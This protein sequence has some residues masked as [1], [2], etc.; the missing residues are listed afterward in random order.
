M[1]SMVS[2]VLFS[3]HFFLL[4]RSHPSMVGASLVSL[5]FGLLTSS[6]I[7]GGYAHMLLGSVLYDVIRLLGFVLYSCVVRI[8]WPS[9]ESEW[10]ICS[11]YM[12]LLL[13][14][15]KYKIHFCVSSRWRYLLFEPDNNLNKSRLRVMENK[16]SRKRSPHLLVHWFKL[17]SLDY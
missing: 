1:F 13:N 12:S 8:F 17:R 16:S 2:C 7:I 6:F 4:S 14:W 9:V 10:L 3:L 11:R 15:V 5:L